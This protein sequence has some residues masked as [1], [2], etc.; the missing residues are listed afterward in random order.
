MLILVIN[1]G[2]SSIKYQLLNMESTTVVAKGLVERIGSRGSTLTH[3]YLKGDKTEKVEVEQDFPSHV[4]G[5][6]TIVDLLTDEKIGVIKDP[7][8]VTAVGH[9]VV[10]GESVKAPVL[11]TKEIKDFIR[12]ISPLAPLHNPANLLGIEVA[13]QFFKDIPQVVVFDTSFHQTMP[14]KAFRYAIPD[15][16][17][18]DYKIR[19]YG[20][21]GTSHKY[22]RSQSVKHL[23]NPE[24]RII[25]IHLGNGSSVTAINKKGESV[26]TSMGFTPL[27]GLVMGTRSGDID[28]SVLFYMVRECGVKF[29]ELDNL[30]NKQSGMLAL[31]G[32]SDAR[33]VG[34]MHKEGDS[35]AILCLDLYSY[36]V[37]KYIGAYMAALNGA[38][39][40]VFTAGIGENYYQLRS[41]ICK[42]LEFFGIKLDEVKNKEL[43][44]PDQ[45]V[46]IQASDSKVKILI[47]PTNEEL[48]IANDTVKLIQENGY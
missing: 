17:Y 14:P 24:A 2:S 4:E 43:N 28:P 40:I 6:K 47:V 35:K 36:R 41:L 15:K 26:D 33:D 22:V 34:E 44:S 7:S 32:K 19:V 46:E 45:V 29:E 20:A 31:T 9:R 8:E 21:H 38:E 13:E 48:E 12:N 3:K 25:T 30:L 1:A 10:Q 39:A 11:V 5:M 16:F 42:D 18:Y 27:N 23:N 37:K